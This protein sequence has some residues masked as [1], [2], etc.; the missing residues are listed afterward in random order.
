MNKNKIA[1]IICANDEEK[2]QECGH[3][4]NRLIIPESY[5]IE[6]LAVWD[7]ASMTGGYQEGMSSSDAKYKVYLHQDVFIIYP[8]FIAEMLAIFQENTQIGMIGCVGATQISSDKLPIHS[9]DRGRL[10][11]NLLPKYIDYQ[12]AVEGKDYQKVQMVDGLL[13]ATQYDITW[14]NDVFTGWDFY[15]GS[16][17]MEM[18]KIG[19][20][21]VVPYQESPW[22]YH[23]N[24]TSRL[25]NYYR[26]Y[27]V[28]LKE[29]LGVDGNL[30]LS[31]RSLEFEELQEQM[32]DLLDTWLETGKRAELLELFGNAETRKY[33]SLRDYRVIADIEQSERR[34]LPIATFWS[35]GMGRKELF[36]KLQKLRFYLKRLEY[37][38]EE[39]FECA[40]LI[41]T[42]SKE[43]ISVVLDEYVIEKEK[44]AEKIRNDRS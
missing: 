16:Q 25:K 2:L 34:G 1:F 9:W 39:G 7:A 44:V 10:F 37:D 43:A 42:Y 4:I 21:V 35:D 36:A 40:Y 6:L 32:K 14:R 13:I 23:D 41:K 18:Q 29:Y 24:K 15:D 11:H 19:K 20:E 28:F 17:A 8:N 27:A 33:L 22:C 38:A 12:N 3:Y 31:A 5:E 26:D 30:V